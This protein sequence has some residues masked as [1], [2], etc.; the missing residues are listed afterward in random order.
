MNWLCHLTLRHAKS[1]AGSWDV[2]NI[3][4]L[5][6]DPDKTSV[7]Y[8]LQGAKACTS[9]QQLQKYYS[10]KLHQ[11][12]VISTFFRPILRKDAVQVFRSHDY[13]RMTARFITALERSVRAFIKL[14]SMSSVAIRSWAFVHYGLSSSLLLGLIKQESDA[15]DTRRIQSELIGILDQHSEYGG[16]LFVVH[17][18]ALKALQR[19]RKLAD[20]E[21]GLGPPNVG[22]S[23]EC[24]VKLYDGLSEEEFQRFELGSCFMFVDFANSYS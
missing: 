3:H 10:F 4:A 18:K 22:Q 24:V 12:F 11:N 17:K 9:I 6:H 23:P 20:Q 21:A 7:Y 5:F 14:Q 2:R 13:G 8:H 16:R 1:E 19:L 15:G